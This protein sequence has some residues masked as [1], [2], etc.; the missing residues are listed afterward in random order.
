MENDK[1]PLVFSGFLHTILGKALQSVV[2]KWSHLN[3]EFKLSTHSHQGAMDWD[4]HWLRILP[5]GLC[6]ICRRPFHSPD[7]Q[8]PEDTFRCPLCKTGTQQEMQP[9][10][11][12]ASLDPS[13][14]LTRLSLLPNSA[15]KQCMATQQLQFNTAAKHESLVAQSIEAISTLGLSD[16]A[17]MCDS[18]ARRDLA[19]LPCC[20][21]ELPSA[22]SNLPASVRCKL[23][24]CLDTQNTAAAA[25]VE[26]LFINGLHVNH[27]LGAW[28]R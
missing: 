8:L 5:N 12:Q 19:S 10:T 21:Q 17:N 16:L 1:N 9:P 22:I 15:L 28:V 13:A 24:T 2:T 20:S 7:L 27:L 11:S 6:V 26:Q 25:I 23:A 14:C 4:L 3:V 18:H